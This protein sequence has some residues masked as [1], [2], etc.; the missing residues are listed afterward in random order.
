MLLVMSNWCIKLQ[1]GERSGL[2]PMLAQYNSFEDWP[3]P[4]VYRDLPAL[5]SKALMLT[6][7]AS[8]EIWLESLRKH[9]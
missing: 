4:L 6:R 3:R 1:G 9:R 5:P 7:R 8:P 2:A